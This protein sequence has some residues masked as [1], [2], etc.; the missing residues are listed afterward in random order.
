[1]VK[2]DLIDI[3]FVYLTFLFFEKRS[4]YTF[5]Y[6]GT[7]TK[8]TYLSVYSC[9]YVEM[10][11]DDPNDQPKCIN[12]LKVVLTSFKKSLGL[13]LYRLIGLFYVVICSQKT[14][15]LGLCGP[16]PRQ[17][18]IYISHRELHPGYYQWSK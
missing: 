5:F 14:Q 8:S 4:F 17:S 18:V 12:L 9:L 3:Q 10:I 11:S 16:N 1:M 15:N 7:G 13:L 2:M 6:V